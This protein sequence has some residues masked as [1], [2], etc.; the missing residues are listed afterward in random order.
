MKTA[1][2]LNELKRYADEPLYLSGDVDLE[3]E[4]MERTGDVLKASP[5]HCEGYLSVDEEEYLLSLKLKVTLTLPSARSLK[6]VEQEMEV[7]LT[8]I[9]LPPESSHKTDEYGKNEVV[10]VLEEDRL[11]IRP[12]IID[13]ILIAIPAQVFTE[14][15]LESG[16]MPSG[17]DWEVVSEEDHQSS[18]RKR[19]D[20]EGD[21]RFSALKSL[22]SDQNET[23]EDK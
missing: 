22:F 1:W 11:D 13:S 10:I 6:P 17:N 9:Y 19:L 23:E 7:S 4:L 16:E 20:E 2:S 8:E 5:I 12:A 21:P 14:E 18:V 15:E 3:Q